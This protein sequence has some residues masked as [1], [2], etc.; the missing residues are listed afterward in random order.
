MFRPGPTDYR[1][2]APQ[3]VGIPRVPQALHGGEPA[4]LSD[5]PDR[6]SLLVAVTGR[7]LAVLG[8][9]RAHRC[10]HRISRRP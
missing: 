1:T 10:R 5:H 6:A 4:D 3:P 2:R 9:D 7:G 8:I